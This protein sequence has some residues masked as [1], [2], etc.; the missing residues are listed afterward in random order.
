MA[1]LVLFVLLGLIG[2]AFIL[3]S[4]HESKTERLHSPIISS[5]AKHLIGL[6]FIFA[7][8]TIFASQ[9]LIYSR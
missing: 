8:F 5:R 9:F 7:G 2:G 1:R 6:L 4:R 3:I